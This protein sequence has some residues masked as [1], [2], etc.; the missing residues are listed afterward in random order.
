MMAVNERYQG[1]AN[2]HALVEVFRKIIESYQFTPTELR[3]A[4]MLAQTI[5]ELNLMRAGVL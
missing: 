1:D 2:F 3:E 5:N 4:L